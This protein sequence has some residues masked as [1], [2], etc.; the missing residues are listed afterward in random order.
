MIE[1]VKAQDNLLYLK[2]HSCSVEAYTTSWQ[3]VAWRQ[4]LSNCEA[5]IYTK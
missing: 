4:A 3:Q 1:Y 2:E 5:F